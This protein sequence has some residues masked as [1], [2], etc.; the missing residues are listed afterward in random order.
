MLQIGITIE[1]VGI[2]YAVL[3]FA[4][5]LGPP[6]AGKKQYSLSIFLFKPYLFTGI[7][8]LLNVIYRNIAIARYTKYII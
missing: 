7:I 2:I 1:E 5:C 3:P 4:S 6:I 8:I